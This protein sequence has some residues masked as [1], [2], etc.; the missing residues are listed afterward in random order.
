[1]T[2]ARLESLLLA[3]AELLERVEETRPASTF[4]RLSAQ[5]KEATDSEG[6]RDV[7]RSIVAM[8]GGM[9]SFQDLVLQNAHGVLP[10]QADFDS[11]RRAIFVEARREL[12]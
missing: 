6:R 9:G 2:K 5:L 11:L 4:R 1:M 10:E 7:A 3:V 8:Y 12:R